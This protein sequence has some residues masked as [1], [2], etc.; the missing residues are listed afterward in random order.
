[1]WLKELKIAVIEKDTDK[2]SALLDDLPQLE[3]MK[4]IEESLFLLQAAR[5]LFESLKKDTQDS[6]TQMRKS[7][8]FLKSTQA[9]KTAKLDLNF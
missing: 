9:P 6:M 2:I 4:E 8:N 3:D 7:I 1:M 5:E